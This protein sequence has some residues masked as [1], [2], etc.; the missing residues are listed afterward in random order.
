MV[1]TRAVL[2]HMQALSALQGDSEVWRKAH[3]WRHME[4]DA[5]HSQVVSALQAALESTNVHF[6]LHTLET[7]SHLHIVCDSQLTTSV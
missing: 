5:L 4:L 1:Q 3:F 6:L 2:S 7:L